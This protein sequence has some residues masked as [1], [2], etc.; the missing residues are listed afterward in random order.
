[1]KHSQ[2]FIP[3]LITVTM[4]T[5]LASCTTGDRKADLIL[6]GGVVY[7]VDPGFTTAEAI[8]IKDHRIID[9]GTTEEITEKYTSDEV[10]DLDGDFVYP[11]WIDAHCHFFGYGMNLNS[12][13][14]VGTSSVD[15]ITEILHRHHERYGGAWITGR[16]WDQNDWEMQEFPDRTMLNKHFPDT[17]VLLRRIDGHA[18]WV[19]SKALEL[20]G[21]TAGTNVEGGTVML[22]DGVPSGILI[23]NAIGLVDRLIPGP[24]RKEIEQA[25]RQ[26]EQNCFRVGLTSVNDAGLTASTIGLIDSLYQAGTL[27]IRINAWLSATGENFR[28]YM[29]KGPMQ[30]DYLTVNT[31]KLFADGALGSRGAR[32][33]EPYSDD[34]GNKGL[35]ITPEEELEM[36]CRKAYE[37]GFI[38]ATHCIGDA[39][40]RRMLNLYAKI[41]EEENDRRWRIE[42]AQ[43][44]HPEDFE[45]FGRYHITPSVQPTHATSDMYWAEQ[46]LGPERMDGAYAYRR[47]LNENGWLA[48]GSDFPVEDINPLYGFYAAVAR[49]DHE[50]YPPGG[51]MPGQALT[52]EQALRAMTIWAARAGFEENLKGSIQ[53][54]KLADLVITGTDLMTAP[55]EELFRI[56][57]K[58]TYS[59]G[60]LVYQAGQ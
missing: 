24:S 60:E 5:T 58:A 13:D 41:L 7:T 14:L 15:E 45:L 57:V 30:N 51:F 18:A 8:A 33:I 38:V 52:R 49:K 37:H 22:K 1:M 16:G 28:Q 59:G 23:D 2:S 29:E 26:A 19:N 40:N 35:F 6:T 11:G 32:M 56:P 4:M 31:L 39:A 9:V 53:K 55:E 48:A 21:V 10:K 46:R 36:H 47:L 34:P 50:G 3:L 27:R 44:I 43:V 20:A 25:L 54:G 12:A 17:P 42:H